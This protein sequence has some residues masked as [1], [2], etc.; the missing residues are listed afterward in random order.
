MLFD[1]LRVLHLKKYDLFLQMQI[2]ETD[3][4]NYSKSIHWQDP[5]TAFE[6]RAMYSSDLALDSFFT[7]CR[8]CVAQT[9][10]DREP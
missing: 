3:F 7:Y 5:N 1:S 8:T 6:N 4:N 10:L 2:I 9:G